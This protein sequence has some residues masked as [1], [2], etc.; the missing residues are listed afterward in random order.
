MKTQEQM[1]LNITEYRNVTTSGILWRNG[2]KLTVWAIDE[3][4]TMHI[5]KKEFEKPQAYRIANLV[6]EKKL[7]NPKNW[8]RVGFTFKAQKEEVEA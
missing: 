1:Q 8:S 6:D 4:G 7:I 5:H 3:T 2:D